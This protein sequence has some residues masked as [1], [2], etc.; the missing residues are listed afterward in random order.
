MA[1]GTLVSSVLAL[2]L[3]TNPLT[4]PAPAAPAVVS[5]HSA[6]SPRM[7][8]ADLLRDKK[9]DIPWL[10][11]GDAPSGNKVN[12]PDHVRQI[13]AQPAAPKRQVE[14]P[15]RVDEVRGR[16]QQA[17]SD[18]A[19][20]RGMMQEG[21]DSKAWWRSPP[22]SGEDGR[23]LTTGEPL[24]VLIAGGGLAGLV[25]AAACNAKGMKVALF[26]QASSY[27]PYGGPIQIQS[28]ALR[29]IQRINP[30]V[31]EELVAAGR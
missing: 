2:S 9:L 3:T 27:A 25:T 5:R 26:E 28:N 8:I 16:A 15:G 6:S 13:L 20:L 21:D 14:S 23:D 4:H 12:M 19:A 24:R 10:A 29:A 17:A 22:P 18:A 31:Y 7:A 1:L 30:R 11:E